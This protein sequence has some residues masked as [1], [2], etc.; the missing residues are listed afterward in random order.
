M[1]RAGWDFLLLSLICAIGSISLLVIFSINRNLAFNQLIFWGIGLLVLWLFS[2][3][4]YKNWQK[5]SIPFY[6]ASIASLALLLFIGNPVRGSVRWIDLGAFRFQPSE[7]AKI[8]TIFI[9]SAFYL[10]RSAKNLKNLV[11]SFF[12]ILPSFTLILIQPDIGNSLAL[13]AIWLGIS[14]V[15]GFRPKHILVF[16]LIIMVTTLFLYK[17][18]A[19]YQKERVKIFINPTLDPLGTGYQIIQSKITVGSGQFLGRGLSQSSQ[20]Q[21]KFLPEA[22]SDFIFASIGESLGFLGAGIIVALYT[23]LIFRVLA[24]S[25]LTSR[26]GQLLIVGSTSYLLLQFSVNVGMNM[27]LI[28]VTGITFPLV[29]YGGSSLISTL[30]LFGTIFSVKRLS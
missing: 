2:F 11:L 15:C 6:L 14:L 25:K 22:E 5:L 13:I 28:P 26:F 21:L 20:S 9:L 27:G 18:L 30:F 24:I 1:T 7:I 16:A 12:I 23:L 3:F 4:D 10:E 17:F 19:P 8:A 29:S